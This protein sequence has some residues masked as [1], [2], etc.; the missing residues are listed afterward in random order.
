MRQ[1]IYDV[2]TTL[3]GFIGGDGG[4]VSAFVNAGDHVDAY[5]ARLKAYDTVVM[6]RRTYE[7]GYAFGLKPGQRAYPHMAH[8]VFSRSLALPAAS[9][10]EV[11]RENWIETIDQLRAAPGG[12][13]YLCGGGAFAGYL[14][15]HGRIDRLIVKLNP[16]LLGRGVPLFVGLE[17]PL[18]L[19]LTSTTRY[20]SGVALLE[21]AVARRA[22]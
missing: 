17:R 16:V 2:A 21:Y 22:A 8:H 20:T 19:R 11:V 15:N 5:L 12:D 6:G 9:D 14:A 18:S 4:D 10:V 13:I 1:I 7:F 3:D